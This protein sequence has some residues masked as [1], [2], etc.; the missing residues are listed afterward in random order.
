MNSYDTN[1]LLVPAGW[2]G[3]PNAYGDNL[4]RAGCGLT[5]GG[6]RESGKGYGDGPADFYGNADGSYYAPEII[7]EGAP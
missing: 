7:T 6:G 4:D 3:L 5:D 1:K 2:G